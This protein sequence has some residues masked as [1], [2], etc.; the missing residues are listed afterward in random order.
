VSELLTSLPAVA[1]RLV[2]DPHPLCRQILPPTRPGTRIAPE[3]ALPA[4]V[5]DLPSLRGFLTWYRT[6][7]LVPVEMP[8]IRQAFGHASRYELR[9][10][11]DLDRRLRDEPRLRSFA[12]AS[13][14]VGRSQLWRLLPM[15][16]Q[17]L[18]RRYWHRLE[19]G[20]A[21][22]WHMLIYGVVLSVFSLPLRQGLLNYGRQTLAGFVN[23]AAHSLRLPEAECQAL[24]DG[25]CGTLGAGTERVL[26]PGRTPLR[27]CP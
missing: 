24:L 15:R 4:A 3:A 12:G 13:R 23:S 27:L 10:L 17:R 8:A 16:D 25:E 21:H 7:L 2:G 18:V 26:G 5:R 6:E 22:G 9:E 19:E 11:L 1:A 20:Q 14:A